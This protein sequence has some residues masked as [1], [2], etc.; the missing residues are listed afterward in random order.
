M[1]DA[2]ADFVAAADDAHLARAHKEV[3]ELLAKRL[4]DDHLTDILNDDLSTGY[5]PDNDGMTPTQFLTQLE[6]E[7]RPLGSG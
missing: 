2:V 7:L 4:E 1:W 3:V 5:S 6:L